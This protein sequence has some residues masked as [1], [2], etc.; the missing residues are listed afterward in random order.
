MLGTSLRKQ[1]FSFCARALMI[2]VDRLVEPIKL[3]G[4]NIRARLGGVRTSRVFFGQLE[5]FVEAANGF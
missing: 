1:L 5:Q 2:S 3:L 4:R